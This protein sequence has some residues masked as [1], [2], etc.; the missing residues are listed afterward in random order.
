MMTCATPEIWLICWASWASTAS[1]TVGSGKV[2]DGADRN[3][4]GEYAGLTLRE[5]G[6]EGRFFGNWPLAAL[7][8]PCT[9]LAAPSMLRL[10]SNWMVTAALPRELGGVLCGV[11]GV[12]ANWR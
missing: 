11:A 8:A 10:R 4:I 2:S 6:G 5:G 9:S 7:M 3:R 12:C 1:L